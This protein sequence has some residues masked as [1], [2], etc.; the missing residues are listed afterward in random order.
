[1]R[2]ADRWILILVLS[3]AGPALGA[4]PEHGRLLYETHCGG[5]HYPKIHGRKATRISSTVQLRVEV[6]RWAAQTDRRFTPV[7][8]DDIADYL[9]QSHYRLPK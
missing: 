9:N 8:L 7:E 2:F 6:A 5:C 4:D 3:G 1:M